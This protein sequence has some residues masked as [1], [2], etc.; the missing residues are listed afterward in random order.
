MKKWLTLILIVAG[1]AI[2][3]FGLQ[4]F[5]RNN[6]I[7]NIMELCAEKE[8][9]NFTR[10]ILEKKTNYQ[11]DRILKGLQQGSLGFQ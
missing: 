8:G 7:N 6:V 10:D 4:Y 9:C 2:A 11:L 5:Y 1:F 3:I